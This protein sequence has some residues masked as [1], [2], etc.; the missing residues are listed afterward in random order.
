MKVCTCLAGAVVGSAVGSFLHAEAAAADIPIPVLFAAAESDGSTAEVVQ[1]VAG[2]CACAHPDVLVFDGN[3]H[4]KR[5]LAVNPDG[6]RL[7]AA[8]DQLIAHAAG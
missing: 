8:V 3:R 7:R 4:G 5:L 6:A 1:T 2:R